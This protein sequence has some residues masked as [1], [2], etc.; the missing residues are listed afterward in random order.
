[1][2]I[3]RPHCQGVL[4][5]NGHSLSFGLCVW[6]CVQCCRHGMHP[7]HCRIIERLMLSYREALSAR[8]EPLKS[9]EMDRTRKPKPNGSIDLPNPH[10]APNCISLP[11]FAID[12]TWTGWTWWTQ[13]DGP[14]TSPPLFP[15]A[16]PTWASY[17]QQDAFKDEVWLKK[18][19]GMNGL[20]GHV[21]TAR[22]LFAVVGG[23]RG[24]QLYDPASWARRG[25]S[26]GKTITVGASSCSQWRVSF[27][28][29]AVVFLNNN[30]VYTLH[31]PHLHPPP[32]HSLL[33]G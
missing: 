14:L 23:N 22:L 27:I 12:Q 2:V 29:E 9:P 18:R 1:M 3:V 31:P 7:L 25:G 20:A 13:N 32:I 33:F 10:R 4:V 17:A 24:W 21:L 6:V 26:Q 15:V 28:N 19:E 30:Y 16:P 8:Y 5:D 11:P